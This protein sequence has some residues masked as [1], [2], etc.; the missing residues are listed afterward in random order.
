MTDTDTHSNLSESLED[1]IEAI[2]NI[3][4]EKKEVLVGDIAQYLGVKKPS[5]SLAMRQ[6]KQRELVNYKQYGPIQLTPTGKKYA[7]SII[8]NHT[9][10]KNFL[11]TMLHMTEERANEVACRIEHIM[12]TEEIARLSNV[13]R[14]I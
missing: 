5:V 7:D 6:L 4:L 13:R 8:Q 10:V 9:R 12:T 11:I 2:R 14:K 1:Y 3:S